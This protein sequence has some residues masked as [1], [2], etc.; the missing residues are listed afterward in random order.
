MPATRRAIIVF[1]APGGPIIRTPWLPAA[2]IRARRARACRLHPR[3]SAR[4]RVGRP[5]RADRP[6]CLRRNESSGRSARR[7]LASDR[8]DASPSTT[9]AWRRSGRENAGAPPRRR[10]GNP[11]HAAGRLDAAVEGGSPSAECR[12]VA[13]LHD[14]GRGRECPARWA[15]R[16]ADRLRTSA[17]ASSHDPVGGNSNLSFGW[18][19]A[20]SRLHGR[21]GSASPPCRTWGRTTHRPG[22]DYRPRRR[23]R[24]RAHRG[25]HAGA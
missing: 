18:R 10:R 19:C 21:S 8:T 23:D 9:D 13:P 3:K 14:A 24:R 16:D 11:E 4:L 1:P 6:F 25:Q 5:R 7:R 2:A 12:R 17:G 15:G 22:P 20:R